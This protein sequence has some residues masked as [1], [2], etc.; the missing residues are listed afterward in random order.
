MLH[1]PPPQAGN[2]LSISCATTTTRESDN[3]EHFKHFTPASLL[4][5]RCTIFHKV[6]HSS[7]SLPSC[8]GMSLKMIKTKKH[9]MDCS[10]GSSGGSDFDNVGI[11]DS[12]EEPSLL[13]GE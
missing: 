13:N 2:T 11:S 4:L 10:Q 1:L 9:I 3:Q 6:A 5:E 7:V 12:L 8:T